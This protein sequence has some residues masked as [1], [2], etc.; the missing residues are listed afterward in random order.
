MCGPGW[1]APALLLVTCINNAGGLEVVRVRPQFQFLLMVLECSSGCIYVLIHLCFMPIFP[2]Q[3]P[4]LLT[5]GADTGAKDLHR[6]ITGNHVLWWPKSFSNLS[7]HSWWF[8]FFDGTELID[9]H[10]VGS[11]GYI[12]TE[13]V[14]IGISPKGLWWNYFKCS[15]W[16]FCLCSLETIRR[17]RMDSLHSPF[18][19]SLSL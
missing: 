3:W 14:H 12:Q 13:K 16:C 18:S 17:R 7:H 8:F 6:P 4:G 9:T 10:P 11:W 15:F 1:R 19:L 2:L 5:S